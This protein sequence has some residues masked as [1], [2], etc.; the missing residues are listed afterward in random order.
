MSLS[1][2]MFFSVVLAQPTFFLIFPFFTFFPADIHESSNSGE[3]YF[4]IDYVVLAC[5]N[6][7][8][9]L[10]SPVP[11][12]LTLTPWQV[13]VIF[14]TPPAWTEIQSPPQHS[15]LHSYFQSWRM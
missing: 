11:H 10:T 3:Q 9:R 13:I 8:R 7:W 6:I 12:S 15:I 1:L 5:G 14:L 2:K 4:E